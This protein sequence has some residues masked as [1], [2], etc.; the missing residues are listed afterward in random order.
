M[1]RV[2]ITALKTAAIITVL[3]TTAACGS[4]SGDGGSAAGSLEQVTVG[5]IQAQGD[6]EPAVALPQFTHFAA[7]QGGFDHLV[8]VAYVQP[9]ARGTVAVDLD[10]QLR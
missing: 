4:D 8:D 1:R 7:A 9:V 3:A 5:I 10:L 2:G 6:R